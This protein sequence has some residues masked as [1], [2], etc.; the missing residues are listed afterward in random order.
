MLMMSTNDFTAINGITIVTVPPFNKVLK[1]WKEKVTMHV[2]V[3]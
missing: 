2:F 3:D 1:P